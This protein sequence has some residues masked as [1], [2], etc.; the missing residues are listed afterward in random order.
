M[1][2][3]GVGARLAT[4][5]KLAG[6]TQAQLAQS[7]NFS[8]SLVRKVEQGDLPASQAF[9]A[10]AAHVLK[11]EPEMLTGAPYRETIEQE[12][13]LDGLSDLRAILVE[14]QY[15]A[16]VAPEPLPQLAS[17]LDAIN[18]MYRNDKGRQALAR[19]PI[20]LRQLYG[21]ARDA[22]TDEDRGRIFSL[23]SSGYVTAER[24]CRRFGYMSL[25]APALDRLEWLAT[26]A[27]DPL[28]MPQAKVKR[29]RV[30]MYLNTYDVGLDLVEKGLNEVRGDDERSNAVRGYAHLCG[31]MSA[32]RGRKPDIA[33]SHIAAA[34][35]LATRINGE[36]DAYG[37]LFG[38][39]NVGIHA[40][41]V[42]LE[43]GDPGRAAHDGS[44]LMLPASIAPPRAGHHWQ[45]TARAWVLTGKP[46]NA[47]QALNLARKVAPQQ[48][49]LHPSVR[50][51]LRSIAE[52]ER[53]QTDSLT[54]FAGWVGMTL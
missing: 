24:L 26:Q 42:E 29:A 36:S 7:A 4:Y 31:A 50:E 53:R 2:D 45:D 12:G 15:V 30:L 46:N 35:E 48:T 25:C 14:G 13:P 47:L 21:A 5:R 40:C 32:A 38:E 3:L 52:S 44:A 20:L 16:A 6:K 10:S 51:T 22:S 19:L 41:A 43:V 8:L 23:L 33:R 28:F 37:T 39:G 18:N 54:A 27:D 49:R 11:I 9:I 17:E 34:R 1:S